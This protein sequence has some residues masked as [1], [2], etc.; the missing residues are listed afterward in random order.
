M[1]AVILVNNECGCAV[2]IEGQVLNARKDNNKSYNVD[3]GYM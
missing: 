2:G 3:N 1:N